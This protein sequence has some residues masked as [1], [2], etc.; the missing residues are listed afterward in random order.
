MAGAYLHGLAQ[1][2]DLVD[3][4]VAGAVDFEHVERAAFGDFLAAR[5][6]VVEI[7]LR[8]AGAVQA[9][10]KNAGDGGLAGAARAAEKIGV[11][12]AVLL[13]GVGERLR[14]M[15]LADDIGETLRAIL[16]GYDLIGHVEFQIYDWRFTN[17]QAMR[18][19]NRNPKS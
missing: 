5:I 13:D 4:A 1:L 18:C 11:G 12:D 10:G 6:V 19:S 17:L 8:A 14:D 3:A 16:S 15:L 2:A 9:F 7:H